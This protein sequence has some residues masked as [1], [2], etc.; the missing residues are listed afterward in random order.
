MSPRS[1]GGLNSTLDK[2]Q[3]FLGEVGL[4]QTGVN[5]GL[6]SH[7]WYKSFGK[8]GVNGA[9]VLVSEAGFG[10]KVKDTQDGKA[11]LRAVAV[12][13]LKNSLVGPAE[14][15]FLAFVRKPCKT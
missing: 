9:K 12:Q 14:S 11:S 13:T 2:C 6:A 7:Q 8:Q 10:N 15:C 5:P 4:L 1:W 3:V